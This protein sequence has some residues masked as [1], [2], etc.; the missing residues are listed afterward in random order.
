MMLPE[1]LIAL[2]RTLLLEQQVVLLVRQLTSC[3]KIDSCFVCCVLDLCGVRRAM[4]LLCLC[5]YQCNGINC[6]PLQAF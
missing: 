2:C 6:A 1:E 5:S 3:K 4:E